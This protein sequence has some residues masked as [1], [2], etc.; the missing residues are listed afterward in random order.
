MKWFGQR[1]KSGPWPA[2]ASDAAGPLR[3]SEFLLSSVLCSSSGLGFSFISEEG[4][5]VVFWAEGF[6]S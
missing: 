3:G 6:T 1:K 2:L 4:K 5:G